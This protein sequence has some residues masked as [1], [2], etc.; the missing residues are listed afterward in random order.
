MLEIYVPAVNGTI[1]AKLHKIGEQAPYF[2][3]TM[4][5]RDWGGCQHELVLKHA[6]YLKP[7]VDLH[8]STDD[9]V[10]MHAVPNAVYWV[11][12]ALPELGDFRY[13]PSETPEQCIAI[14]QQHLRTDPGVVLGRVQR[15][16]ADL[17]VLH[18]KR[19]VPAAF[20]RTAIEREVTTIVDEL[21]QQ[22]LAEAQIAKRLINNGIIQ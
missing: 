4:A 18:S 19:L 20:I 7:V 12:G 22:W 21:R 10:P 14:L 11:S 6:P 1:T 5:G 16:T 17:V 13:R 3:V 15:A 2:S 8:L 9:G